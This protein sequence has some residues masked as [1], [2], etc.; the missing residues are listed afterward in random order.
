MPAVNIRCCLEEENW[1]EK[2]ESPAIKLVWRLD[3]LWMRS[4]EA[5][6]RHQRKSKEAQN[7]MENQSARVHA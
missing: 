3:T 1:R 2:E 6:K 5:E 4:Y 7:I